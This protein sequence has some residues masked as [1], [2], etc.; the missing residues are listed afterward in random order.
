MKKIG[1]ISRLENFFLLSDEKMVKSRLK[2]GEFQPY[3][4]VKKPKTFDF[5]SVN[6]SA[7]SSKSK[8]N[9]TNFLPQ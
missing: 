2:N 4:S 1:N 8:S 5:I 3:N 6:L 9:S 7:I